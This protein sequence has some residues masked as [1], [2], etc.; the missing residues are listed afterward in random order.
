MDYVSIR[1]STLRGDQKINF[2]VYFKLGEKMILYLREGDSFEGTRLKRLK[3]KKL[4]KMY[5]L[6]HDEVNYRDYVQKSIESAYDNNSKKD[7][8]TRADVIQ[9]AQQTN[10]EEV[11]ENPENAESYNVA[12]E[13]SSQYVKFIMSNS[14]AL[15]AIM[16]IENT[17][18]SVA[19][20]GVNVA[21][22]A[23]ALA[24]KLGIVDPKQTQL[25]TLGSLLHDLGHHGATVQPNRLLSS[26]KPEELEI[27]KKHPELGAQKVQDKKHFDPA[28]VNI[29]M[30]HEECVDGS[31]Y[32]S[33]LKQS[34][35]DDLVQIVSVCN[36]LDRLISFENVPKN[37]AT[38]K[39]MVERVG[40]HPLNH[41]Q[42]LS[43]I[44]KSAL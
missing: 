31:G 8:Q 26:M 32:P 13:A 9:G 44:L 3:E 20:H 36:A 42:H 24:N 2:N 15:K 18:Q 35:Q 12:K 40:K 21:T 41:I 7:I 39:L 22:L 30:K 28:V 37:E 14:S 33:G 34:E 6:N 11:F 1:V 25:L 4:K 27:Y 29:I 38:K 5:I 23:V 43:E 10:T 19:H 17:D 16:S